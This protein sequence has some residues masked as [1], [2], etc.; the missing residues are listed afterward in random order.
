ML[1]RDLV[2]RLMEM[3][4][5]VEVRL[6]HQPTWPFEYDID[7]VVEVRAPRIVTRAEFEE[8][9]DDDAEKVMAQADEGE[10]ALVD[11]GQDA[12]ETI[13]YIGEGRQLRYLPGNAKRELGWGRD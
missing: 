6:A 11:E 4:Q 7:E 8:M 5:E 13:V 12:P 1:V 2:E 3:D 9:S 10:V